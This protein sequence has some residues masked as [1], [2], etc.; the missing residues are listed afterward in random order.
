MNASVPAPGQI[1]TPAGAASH[2]NRLIT[3]ISGETIAFV[4]GR[5][6]S[7]ISLRGWQPWA[8]KTRATPVPTPAPGT[9]G[10][11]RKSGNPA[12]INEVCLDAIGSPVLHVARTDTGKEML[13]PLRS[14]TQSLSD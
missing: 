12:R 8:R 2:A 7:S 9:E 10:F 4:G 3:N 13:I 14:F 11:F 1:W 5:A 6:G